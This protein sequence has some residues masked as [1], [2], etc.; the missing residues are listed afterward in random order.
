MVPCKEKHGAS[1][2]ECWG[3]AQCFGDRRNKRRNASEEGEGSTTN[4]EEAGGKGYAMCTELGWLG[5]R[6]G[7][8][9]PT[10]YV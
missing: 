3:E 1:E 7:W 5:E 9:P 8:R 4:V 10:A 6:E 2:G